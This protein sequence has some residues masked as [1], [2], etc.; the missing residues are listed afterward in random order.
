MSINL[1]DGIIAVILI[2]AGYLAYRMGPLKKAISLLA[3]IVA[4][5]IG[6]RLMPWL[7]GALAR[8]GIFSGGFSV[9]LVFLIVAGGLLAAAWVLLRRFGPKSGAK[10]P[11]RF[12]A[13]GIGVLEAAFLLSILF[14]MLKFLDLPDAHTRS[15]SLFYRPMTHLAPWSFDALRAALPERLPSP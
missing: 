13:A 4:V 12:A 2:A 10:K 8:W 11:G 15:G 6:I 3:S 14:L 9:L 5:I 7:G 1:L